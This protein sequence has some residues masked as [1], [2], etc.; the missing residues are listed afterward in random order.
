MYRIDN[1]SNVPTLPA[2]GPPGT[3]G[4]YSDGNE[5]TGTP[6][7]IVDAWWLNMIQE[8]IRN[9]VVA[10]GIVPDKE[11][12]AQLLAAISA[13]TGG[14]IY[15]PLAGG[16]MTGVINFQDGAF[17]N[18]PP[19]PDPDVTGARLNL[20]ASGP[21]TEPDYCIGV[22]GNG[23]WFG[24]GL[25]TSHFTFYGG[26]TINAR[27][28]PSGNPVQPYDLI[29]LGYL[30]ANGRNYLTGNKTF[31]VA[32]TGNDN[33]GDGS[34]GNPWRTL[35]HAFVYIQ[36]SIDFHGFVVTIQIA[37]GTYT[38]G[39]SA[40]G[41]PI[42]AVSSGSIVLRG[43]TA[44]ATKV[45]IDVVGDICIYATM[46]ASIQ[47]EYLSVRSILSGGAG[48]TAIAADYAGEI[49]IGRNVNFDACSQNH[50]YAGAGGSIIAIADYSISGGAM[51]HAQATLEGYVQLSSQGYGSVHITLNGVPNFSSAFVLAG[52]GSVAAPVNTFGG[53][54]TGPRYNATLNGVIWTG[55]KSVNYFPGD[56][57]GF[58]GT[59]GQYG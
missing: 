20:W 30:Q 19:D 49:L 29:T 34:S 27:V 26:T 15:L 13:I 8:E 42:G 7:T 54:A 59:G 17:P 47:V 11:D 22:E 28:P 57:A 3:Q 2:P 4:F 35:Q 6:A 32:T 39:L 23:M 41:P 25:V 18:A 56:A 16:T 14:N 55:G 37:D 50:L 45:L 40:S 58:V 21:T 53:T 46:G 48:G 44:D 24:V 52:S 9:V 36:G 12:N 31:Y 51:V 5:T 10:A 43:N 38:T 33:T 1:D